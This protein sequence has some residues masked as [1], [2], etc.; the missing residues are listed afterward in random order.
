M[1]THYRLR[2]SNDCAERGEPG[3]R[4]HRR[5]RSGEE[6]WSGT[7]PGCVPFERFSGGRSR[8][9]ARATHRLPAVNPCRVGEFLTG[10]N[11]ENGEDLAIAPGTY[12]AHA[13]HGTDG[14]ERALLVFPRPSSR[15]NECE[16]VVLCRTYSAGGCFY[17]G[18]GPALVGLASAR[19]STLRPFGPVGIGWT[20]N[21]SRGQGTYPGFGTLPGRV[22]FRTVFR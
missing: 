5:F 11:G 19:A 4:R 15:V 14:P 21:P 20:R 3:G 12:V 16:W 18:P 2:S 7:L 8:G 17:V 9:K 13:R 1:G 10:G 22:L 6:H